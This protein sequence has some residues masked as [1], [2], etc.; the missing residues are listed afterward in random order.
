MR[1]VK[2][3]VDERRNY[4]PELLENVRLGV[5]DMHSLSLIERDPLVAASP[6]CYSLV[7]RAQQLKTSMEGQLGKRRRSMQDNQVHCLTLCSS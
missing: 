4:L 6:E 7:T 2:F 3:D 5:L 1:W